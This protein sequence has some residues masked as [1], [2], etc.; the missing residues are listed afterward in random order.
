MQRIYLANN[1]IFSHCC[2]VKPKI[3]IIDVTA[4]FLEIVA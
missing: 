1:K 4:K 2:D 3:R